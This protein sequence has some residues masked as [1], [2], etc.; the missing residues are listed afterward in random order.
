MMGLEPKT[1]CMAR[2]ERDET[3]GDAGPL[4]YWPL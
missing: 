4:F 3:G 2:N 1:F